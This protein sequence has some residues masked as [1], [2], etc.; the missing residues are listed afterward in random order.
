ML[1][2]GSTL[3]AKELLAVQL[4]SI[5]ACPT[6]A[7]LVQTHHLNAVTLATEDKSWNKQVVWQEI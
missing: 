4:I 5:D 7:G 3:I 1:P 6:V 2:Y